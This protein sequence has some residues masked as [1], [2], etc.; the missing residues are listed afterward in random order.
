M[1]MPDLERRLHAI[2]TELQS[3]MT[4]LI[5]KDYPKPSAPSW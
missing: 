2:R 1:R 3:G 4:A 5:G